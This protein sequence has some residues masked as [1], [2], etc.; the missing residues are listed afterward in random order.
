M[1]MDAREYDEI[2][3]QRDAEIA[4]LCA[5]LALVS[6][7]L[8]DSTNAER[9]ARNAERKDAEQ[10]RQMLAK[11]TC[12]ATLYTDD[13]ELSDSSVAPFIDFKRDS[14]E[15]IRLKLQTR[16]IDASMKPIAQPAAEPVPKP[17]VSDEASKGEYAKKSLPALAQPA[18]RLYPPAAEEALDLLV[19]LGYVYDV[20]E[21]GLLQWHAPVAQPVQPA[22]QTYRPLCA[23]CER[24]EGE[25]T[26]LGARGCEAMKPA[27]GE[28]R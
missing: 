14:P 11:S 3:A 17:Y 13:G 4:R 23:R 26:P 7:S 27:Q 15:Q 10:L 21:K 6:S 24:D 19:S 16:A 25:C 8:T 12:A 22:P 1:K 18:N 28:I 2:L 5:D 20:N 9:T